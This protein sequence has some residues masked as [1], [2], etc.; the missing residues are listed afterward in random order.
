M[1]SF[2]HFI[3]TRFNVRTN[4]SQTSQG[5]DPDWLSHRF[6]L[7]EDFCYPS[8]RTQSQQNFKWLVYFNSGTPD[9]YKSKIAEYTE[10]R[11]FIP[12]CINTDCELS[13]QLNC[14]SILNELR[15][16]TQ[17]L[18]TTRLD[19]DDAIS[20]NFVEVVHDNFC[21]QNFEFINLSNGYVWSEGRIYL[22]NYLSNPFISL[23]EKINRFDTEPFKTIFCGDH[24]QLSSLGRIRQVQVKPSWLQVIHG[25][26]VSNRIRGIRQPITSLGNDF[27]IN[28]EYILEKEQFLPYLLDKGWTLLKYPIES[29]LINLPKEKR[30][31][32]K[33]LLRL[34]KK[35]QPNFQ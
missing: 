17:Y 14:T 9:F 35:F 25:K 34:L 5:L 1:S 32:L 7:F 29:I 15:S 28:S 30:E 10:W 18:I 24:T 16:E 21:Q 8:V 22:F 31:E 3:L 20:K 33:R 4:F 6:K 11:N 23:I 13:A 2:E 27:I 26:N 12:I 19:N